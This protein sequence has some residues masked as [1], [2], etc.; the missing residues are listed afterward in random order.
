MRLAPL[1]ARAARETSATGARRRGGFT[2]LEVIVAL[3]ILLFGMTAVIGLLTFGV[4]LG[5]SAELRT[6][7]A[8]VADA[9]VADLE[10]TFFA[11][12]DDASG[13]PR[14]PT[15]IENRELGGVNR[16]VY[17]ARG[18]ANPDRPIEWRVDV[19]M[20][21]KSAGVQRE[22]RFTTLLLR[23]V[24]FGERLRRRFIEAGGSGSAPPT[25]PK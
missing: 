11:G 9:V 23:E 15:A 1:V 16:V 25:P 21:W 18:R 5:R 24:P 22:K 13:T 3:G 4:A 20:T 12:D 14:D 8:S 17:S 6:E 2:I 19:D 7:A 10:E